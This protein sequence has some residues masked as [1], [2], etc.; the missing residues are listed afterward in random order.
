MC[1]SYDSSFTYKVLVSCRKT[2]ICNM[3][4]VFDLALSV[5]VEVNVASSRTEHL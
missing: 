2:Q 3:T 5:T 1:T 4:T